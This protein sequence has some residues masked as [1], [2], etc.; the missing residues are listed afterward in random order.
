MEAAKQYQRADLGKGHSDE[1]GRCFVAA[2]DAS[3][4]PLPC[5]AT[6]NQLAYGAAHTDP[7]WP[8]VCCD[9]RLLPVPV[10]SLFALSEQGSL[11][12]PAWSTFAPD[13]TC[14]YG[15]CTRREALL[16]M[17]A[18]SG[19]TARRAKCVIVTFTCV[20]MAR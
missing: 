13:E 18:I 7:A 20:Y 16:F 5:F 12:L 3:G 15:P 8:W 9:A 17:F 2:R 4:H 19:A 10:W 1:A 14:V 6:V 11:R